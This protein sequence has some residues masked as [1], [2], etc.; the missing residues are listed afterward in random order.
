M[1]GILIIHRE[2]NTLNGTVVFN[3]LGGFNFFV[4]EPYQAEKVFIKKRTTLKQLNIGVG[5][6]NIYT[7]KLNAPNVEQYESIM[8]MVIQVVSVGENLKNHQAGVF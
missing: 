8:I 6:M 7:Q 2:Q 4:Q 1:D 3:M 5:T